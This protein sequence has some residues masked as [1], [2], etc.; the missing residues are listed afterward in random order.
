[1][2]EIVNRFLLAGDKFMPEMHFRQAGFMYS[3]CGSFTN[4]QIFKET[5]DS[6]YIYPNALDKA[7]F[8]HDMTHGSW[9][10]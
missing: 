5:G 9:R 6:K 7:C 4:I 1:M 2:N 10:C 8:Q 3:A